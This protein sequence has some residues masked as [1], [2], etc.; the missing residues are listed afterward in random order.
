MYRIVDICCEPSNVFGK[1][2]FLRSSYSRGYLTRVNKKLNKSYKHTRLLRAHRHWIQCFNHIWSRARTYTRR[3]AA[4]CRWQDGWEVEGGQP[5][6]ERCG[7]W[8]TGNGSGVRVPVGLSI[9][10]ATPSDF[11]SPPPLGFAGSVAR[12][13]RRCWRTSPIACGRRSIRWIRTNP[14]PWSSQNWK[15]VMF[16]LYVLL[17]SVEPERD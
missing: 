15:W 14:A 6:R 4:V 1:I 13:W 5:D 10:R 16:I 3:T 9:A 11:P 7:G 17:V 12:T 2:K 8:L